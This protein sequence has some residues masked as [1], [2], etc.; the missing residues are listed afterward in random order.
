VWVAGLV[1]IDTRPWPVHEVPGLNGICATD[2]RQVRTRSYADDYWY[3][4]TVKWDGRKICED[5]WVWTSAKEID[6]S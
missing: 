6:C 2:A 4:W 1:F 3:G 5:P